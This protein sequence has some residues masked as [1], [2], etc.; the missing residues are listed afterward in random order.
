MAS[1]FT[2]EILSG[3]VTTLKDFAAICAKGF[4]ATQHQ[5]SEPLNTPLVKAKVGHE[6]KR[7]IRKLAKQLLEF[8]E[9]TD[10]Q[11]YQD[12]EKALKESMLHFLSKIVQMKEAKK[13]CADL[14]LEAQL[15]TPPTK[16]HKVVKEMMIKDL[17]QVIEFDCDIK[18]VNELLEDIDGRLS[19]IDVE[20][21]RKNQIE[22]FKK[23]IDY[24]EQSHKVDADH[25]KSSNKWVAELMGSF[26]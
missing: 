3:N 17:K 4:G 22:S 19:T 11:I 9:M 24:H 1:G 23:Q 25:V 6:N 7:A 16:N 21:I 2:S 26:N 12:E 15:W 20:V 13:K 10:E 18:P 5:K 14:L 8:N